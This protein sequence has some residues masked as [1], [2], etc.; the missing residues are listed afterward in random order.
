MKLET[1][2]D[3]QKLQQNTWSSRWTDIRKLIPTNLEMIDIE[4]FNFSE[5]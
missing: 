1:Y 2:G 4:K 3:T 5:F